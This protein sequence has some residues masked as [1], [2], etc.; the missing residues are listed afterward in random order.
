MIDGLNTTEQIILILLPVLFTGL[1]ACLVIFSVKKYYVAESISGS[2]VRTLEKSPD[3]KMK[4]AVSSALL[5]FICA[6]R[7]FREASGL[8][9]MIPKILIIVEILVLMMLWMKPYKVCENGLITQKGFI[10]WNMIRSIKASSQNGKI[11]LKLKRQTDNEITLYC[12][13]EDRDWIGN[14]IWE[15]IAEE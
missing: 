12:R 7:I 15:R 5:I 3:Y 11:V 8:Y 4:G 2:T 6:F 9:E 10:S 14:Y 13:K 1:I